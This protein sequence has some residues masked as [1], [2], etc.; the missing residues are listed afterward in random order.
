MKWTK[1]LVIITSLFCVFSAFAEEVK[2]DPTE[3]PILI[4]PHNRPRTPD[5]GSDIT[6][7]YQSGVIYLNFGSDMG[8]VEIT[9]TNENTG[10]QW[11][12]TDDTAFGAATITT[13]T[14]AGDYSIMIVT[15]TT[16]YIG[17]FSL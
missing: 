10:E 8:E 13:S 12:Q 11:S 5:Y 9:V 6:A 4:D 2:K 14:D 7:Y 16:T 17:T 15:A 3:I 1:L